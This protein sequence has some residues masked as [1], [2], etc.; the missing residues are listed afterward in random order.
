MEQEDP[1]QTYGR[2]E[3]AAFN[4]QEE[5]ATVQEALDGAR[6]EQAYTGARLERDRDMLDQMAYSDIVQPLLRP[7]V[8]ARV[9][10]ALELCPHAQ[11]CLVFLFLTA[12]FFIP[13]NP[14]KREKIHFPL[15]VSFLFFITSQWLWLGWFVWLSCTLVFLSVFVRPNVFFHSYTFLLV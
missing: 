8:C 3:A 1:F 4:L 5:L 6:R 7:Q 2:L 10:S 9:T 12:A 13:L 14:K 11:V 15:S